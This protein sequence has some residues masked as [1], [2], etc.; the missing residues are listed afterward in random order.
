MTNTNTEYNQ[1]T[2]RETVLCIINDRSCYEKIK[3][4][5]ALYK[6]GDYTLQWLNKRLIDYFSYCLIWYA[7]EH[8]G[9]RHAMDYLWTVAD[10]KQIK[11]ELIEYYSMDGDDDLIP[12]AIAFSIFSLLKE[13]H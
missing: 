8:A 2:V 12:P 5:I 7:K 3:N 10:V 1:V 6:T 13:R 11:K 9:N 4:A